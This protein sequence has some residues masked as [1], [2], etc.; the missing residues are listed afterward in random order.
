MTTAQLARAAGADQA[1]LFN[2]E[3]LLGRRFPRTVAGSRE[4]ALVKM[5]HS[6]LRV[7]LA[8][9]AGIV[10]ARAGA[11]NCRGNLLRESSGAVALL[12]D[13]ARFESIWLLNLA[14][15][16]DMAP[17]VRGR[18]LLSTVDPLSRARRHGVDL[19][20]VQWQLS[21][22]LSERLSELDRNARFV[23]AGRR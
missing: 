5:L 12:V 9:A 16:L 22:P 21:R 14:A 7:D 15:A 23:G 1:W 17:K 6:E 3:R 11:S 18:P 4:L 20:L 8:V 19:A 13:P 10:R 2:A